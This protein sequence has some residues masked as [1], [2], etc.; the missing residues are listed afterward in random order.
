[1]IRIAIEGL[2]VMAHSIEQRMNECEPNQVEG[3]RRD[4]YAIINSI[5]MLEVHKYGEIRTKYV[6]SSTEE[7]KK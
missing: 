7:R 3:Y 2:E 5:N 4:L 6:E 1:M